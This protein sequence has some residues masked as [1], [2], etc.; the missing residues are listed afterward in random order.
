[1]KNVNTIHTRIYNKLAKL[2]PDLATLEIGEAMNS[3]GDGVMMDLN[4]DV[5]YT[6]SNHMVI[7]LSHY[8]K[9]PSGD[10]IADPDMEIRVFFDGRGAEALTYQ[11]SFGYQRIYPDE[12][13][14]RPKL[15][16]SLNTFLNTW[17]GN[18]LQQNHRL[19]RETMK[20]Q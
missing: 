13:H 15:K 7:S 16:K 14:V 20:S 11:D 5:L 18:C 9:H 6:G 1:M 2:I 3:L 12:Q 8:Y 4:L 17:L 19:K 10:L